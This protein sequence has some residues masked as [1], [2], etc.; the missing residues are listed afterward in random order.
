MLPIVPFQ[1]VNRVT[2]LVH[3]LSLHPACNGLILALRFGCGVSSGSG[4]TNRIIFAIVCQSIAFL[5]SLYCFS[6]SS[7]FSIFH[8]QTE[9]WL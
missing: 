9:W 3:S 7:R 1:N 5:A 2:A 8:F 6:N 4:Y